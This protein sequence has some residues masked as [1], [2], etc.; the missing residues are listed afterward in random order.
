MNALVLGGNGFIGSHLVDR[1]LVEGHS[2]RVFAHTYEKYRLPLPGVD[3]HIGQFDDINDLAK[4]LVGIDVVYHLISTTVPSSSNK[5]P[6]YD[7]ESNLISTIRLLNEM[8]VLDISRIVYLSSGGTVYGVP[9]ILPIPET[10]PLSPICSYGVI[11]VAIEKYLHMY[12]NQYGIDYLILRASNPYGERQGH[13]GVQGVIG[14]FIA[15][16][17]AN[18]A[19]KIWGDG[20]V[21]RDFIYVKDLAEILVIAGESKV[22]GIFNAGSGIGHSIKDVVG[23]ISKVSGRAIDL[24]FMEG[25]SYDVPSIVLD[26][27]KTEKKYNWVS[28]TEFCSGIEQTW[29][30]AREKYYRNKLT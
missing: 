27:T 22:T 17:L 8:R 16:V 5:N 14:T 26:M 25:R 23:T 24:K 4:S 3:Y 11:K 29:S 1:L 2:V 18:E 15:Q 13:K 9:E 30:W 6:V 7:V 12:Q 28:R 10:H 20:S 21:V 19:I